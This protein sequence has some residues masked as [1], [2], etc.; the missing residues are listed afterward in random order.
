MDLAGPSASTGVSWQTTSRV[1]WAERFT[2][3]EDIR[4]VFVGLGDMGQGVRQAAC[5]L[6]TLALGSAR[7]WIEETIHG[8][9]DIGA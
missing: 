7:R 5:G 2:L 6:A 3:S 4:I 8:C 9:T 1:V